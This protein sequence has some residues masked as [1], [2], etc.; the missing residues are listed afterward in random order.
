MV[1]QVGYGCP[2]SFVSLSEMYTSTCV[3]INIG[4]LGVHLRVHVHIHKHTS[5]HKIALHTNRA[6]IL[7]NYLYLPPF[8]TW[9]LHS[10]ACLYKHGFIKDSYCEL[11]HHVM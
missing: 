3:C 8:L 4:L 11:Y 7:I 6:Q 5:I 10:V 9:I 1:G 2:I